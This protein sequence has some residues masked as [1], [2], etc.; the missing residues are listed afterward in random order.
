MERGGLQNTSGIS[1]K[2]FFQMIEIVLLF[3]SSYEVLDKNDGKLSRNDEPL[4]PGKYYIVG[5]SDSAL[6]FLIKEWSD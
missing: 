2:N 4:Q 1:K 6:S 5:M 3:S